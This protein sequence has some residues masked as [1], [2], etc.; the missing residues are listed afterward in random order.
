M[1]TDT[2]HGSSVGTL[3]YRDADGRNQEISASALPTYGAGLLTEQD[4][5]IV[6]DTGKI[7][8]RGGAVVDAP[9]GYVEKANRRL[10]EIQEAKEEGR[11]RAEKVR[12]SEAYQSDVAERI[13][14][15][16]DEIEGRKA[17]LEELSGRIRSLRE[18]VEQAEAQAAEAQAAAN[19]GSGSESEAQKAQEGLQERRQELQTAVKERRI[20]RSEISALEEELAEARQEKAPEL[21]EER[22]APIRKKLA[23]HLKN[24][25]RAQKELEEEEALLRESGLL[26]THH[27]Q[28]IRKLNP[29]NETRMNQIRTFVREELGE[30][31]I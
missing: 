6:R 27:T 12:Q 3:R 4:C 10:E 30:D 19:V 1:I 23:K 29:S 24:A 28:G 17:D 15:L 16:E 11:R 9:D 26:R 25:I 20:L 13:R 7:R 21:V 22:T 31:A 5:R 14:S 18:E 2:I 8:T